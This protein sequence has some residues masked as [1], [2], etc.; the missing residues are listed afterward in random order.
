MLT[1]DELHKESGDFVA[2][3][4]E[5]GVDRQR[6][7]DAL[8]VNAAMLHSLDP[9]ISA[10]MTECPRVGAAISFQ[11]FRAFANQALKAAFMGQ[12]RAPAATPRRSNADA[13]TVVA[14]N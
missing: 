13:L 7:I 12:E 5:R 2:L 3:L 9:T 14:S 6:L 1:N 11:T 4:L 8:M 10:K